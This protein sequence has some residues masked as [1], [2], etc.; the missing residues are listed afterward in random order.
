MHKTHPIPIPQRV[1]QATL[2][3]LLLGLTILVSAC[4]GDPRAQQQASQAKAQLDQLTQHA[5][6]IGIPASQLKP[7]LNKEQQLSNSSAPFSPFN[8]QPDTAYYN[9]LANQYSKLLSQTQGLITTTTNQ[10]QFQAQNDL[11]VFQQALSHRS[12]QHIGNLQPFTDQVNNDQLMLTSAK[13]PK[14]YA[15]VSQDAQKAI[16]TLGL[17][18][19]TFGQLMAF[20]N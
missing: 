17:M 20:K 8:D 7:I 9:N 18:G 15:L 3:V 14:D 12:S 19:Q 6:Q 1:T 11:Q 4:G 2:V 16:L 5:R 13:Y 10:Y